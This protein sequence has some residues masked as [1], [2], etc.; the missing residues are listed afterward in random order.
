MEPDITTTAEFIP[1]ETRPLNRSAFPR[2]AEIATP[3]A[4]Q[5]NYAAAA[6]FSKA[7]DAGVWKRLTN[8]VL[9]PANPFDQRVPRRLR[10][11][12]V[13]LGALFLGASLLAICFNF[14]TR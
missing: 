9:E 12:A 6:R 5:I 3:S 8:I 4:R 2:D 11:E 14:V 13:V 7:C 1:S 10:Q